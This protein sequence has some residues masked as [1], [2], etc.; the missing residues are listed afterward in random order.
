VTEGILRP[1]D[2][3]RKLSEYDQPRCYLVNLKKPLQL[4]PQYAW[5]GTVHRACLDQR[6]PPVRVAADLWAAEVAKQVE[7]VA[8]L[9]AVA[10]TLLPLTLFNWMGY[11]VPALRRVRAHE[12]QIEEIPQGHALSLTAAQARIGEVLLV[13]IRFVQPLHSN[14]QPKASRHA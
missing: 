5:C 6:L 3:L 7:A 13:P 8:I 9:S 4:P 12:P 1:F 2:Y 10:A 11:R 14:L